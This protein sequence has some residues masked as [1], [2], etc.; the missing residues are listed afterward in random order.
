MEITNKLREMSFCFFNFPLLDF[1]SSS[2]LEAN[3]LWPYAFS[4]WPKQPIM[5]SSL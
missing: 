5:H 4:R 3:E 2:G 1:K